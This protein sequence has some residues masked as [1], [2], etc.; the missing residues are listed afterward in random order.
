MPIDVTHL[1]PITARALAEA[2]DGLR[3][4]IVVSQYNRWITEKL[5]AGAL[6]ALDRESGG[7]AEAYVLPVT[8]TLELPG[9]VSAAATSD[10]FDAVVALG[11]VIKGETAHDAV[12]AQ[13][14]F[15]ELVRISSD[16]DVA[17]GVGVLTVGNA[18]QAEAR[19]GGD[20]GNKG[21]EAMLA[22][23]ASAGIAQALEDILDDD[24]DDDDD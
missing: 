10:A 14:V 1:E 3:V 2:E 12:I 23:L 19:A 11:C 7:V 24:D 21:E 5:E 13:A 16:T 9:I 15:D 6:E 20:L 22:A 18:D 8:G 17:I 4:A